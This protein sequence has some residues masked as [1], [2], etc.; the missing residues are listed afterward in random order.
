MSVA[1]MLEIFS[2]LGK[3]KMSGMSRIRAELNTRHAHETT[4]VYSLG[5]SLK[6]FDY[7]HRPTFR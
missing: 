4:F 3:I 6:I 7:P 5:V 2:V 1:T